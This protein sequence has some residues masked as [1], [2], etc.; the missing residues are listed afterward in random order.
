MPADPAPLLPPLVTARHAACRHDRHRGLLDA[1]FTA[2]G[3][4][5]GV[6]GPP[7]SGKSTLL[8]LLTGSRRPTGGSLRVTGLDPALPAERRRLREVIGYVPEAM[9]VPP[10]CTVGQFLRYVGW[11]R[12]VPAAQLPAAIADSL[13]VT[14]LTELRDRPVRTL[15]TGMRQR[16]LL[17]QAL[18]NR[19]SVVVLDSPTVMLDPEQRSRFLAR[20]VSLRGRCAVVL[21]TPLVQ[22]VAAVCDEVVVLA[23]GRTVFSGTTTDLAGGTDLADGYR[24][25]LAAAH[26]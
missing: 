9:T 23:A 24:R 10:A 25:V 22:S 17:A 11:L 7:R 18:V 14:D 13:L 2:A 8:A 15:S 5:L 19:P 3:R 26:R 1:D 16:V 4:A 20:L 6:L 21:A 12:G